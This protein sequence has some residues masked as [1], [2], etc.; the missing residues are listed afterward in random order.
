M[1][2]IDETWNPI[3]GCLHDCT[4]CWA[5]KWAET[6]LKHV[7]RYRE[8]FKPRLNLVEFRR[9]F[10]PG[11]T[12]FVSDMGDMWGNWVPRDWI[13]AVLNYIKKFPNTQFLFLT[14][15]PSRYFEFL[16]LIPQN[17]ILGATIE[18]NRDKLSIRYSKAPPVS[19]RIKAMAE[20]K[21]LNKLIT[22]EPILDFD[23]EEFVEALR[24]INPKFVYIGYDNYNNRLE[25]PPLWKTRALIKRLEDMGIKVIYGTLRKAWWE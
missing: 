14:K 23:L 17:V 5:R 21:R 9:K 4:Y 22:I 25:E 13:I 19:S 16:D 20:L 24:I 18:T 2:L 15:N 3:T 1:S 11:V 8:G 7:R 10:R 12:V 6:R